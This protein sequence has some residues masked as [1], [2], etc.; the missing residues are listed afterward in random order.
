[1]KFIVTGGAGFIGHNV[2]QLLESQG[3]ECV[4][5]D[6]MTDYG[7]VPRA[8]LEYLINERSKKIKANILDVDLVEDLT[9]RVF[10]EK[11]APDTDAVIHL[12]SFPR[13]K[14]VNQNPVAGANIMG[15]ALVRL[16]ELT[17]LHTV[18]KFVYVSS[19]MVYGDFS[20]YVQETAECDPQGQYAIM[21]FMGEKLVQDYSRRGDCS[22]VI[23]RPSA[24]YGELDVEDRVVSKFFLNAMRGLPIK[25]NGASEMLDFTHVSDT[26]Q[27]IAL[28]AANPEANGKTFNITHSGTRAYTLLDA[29]QLVIDIVGQGTLEVQNRESG[30]PSRGLLS[31]VNANNVLGYRPIMDVQSGFR[32]YHQWLSNSSYWQK[33][34]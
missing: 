2:V 19:S 12:A 24:V 29:A 9:T 3:Y 6:N 23:I 4:I 10:F 14:V 31:T 7:F 30:Y 20:N 22:H 1:M 16:L 26:A 15:T 8:E 11:H 28:A 18:P 25:V 21:K 5:F 33:H 34:L 13:Q 17:K 32:Q 27:G